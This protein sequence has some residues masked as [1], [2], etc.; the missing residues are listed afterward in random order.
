[1]H[2]FEQNENETPNTFRG[3]CKIPESLAS[4][5]VIISSCASDELRG[6]GIVALD[7]GHI[8]TGKD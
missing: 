8:T 3:L 2:G 4:L 5:I 7:T 1:M 6:R